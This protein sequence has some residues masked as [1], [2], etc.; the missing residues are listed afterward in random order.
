VEGITQEHEQ[1]SLLQPITYV[2]VDR[3]AVLIGRYSLCRA[4]RGPQSVR[5]LSEEIT[6]L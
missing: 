5:K 2:A 3:E 6:L 1:V 4:A